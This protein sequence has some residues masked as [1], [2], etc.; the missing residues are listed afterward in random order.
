[1][2]ENVYAVLIPEISIQSIGM[3]GSISESDHMFLSIINLQKHWKMREYK[4]LQSFTHIE[5]H[6]VS[7]ILEIMVTLGAA[8]TMLIVQ[9]LLIGRM[10]YAPQ[11]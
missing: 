7:V 4:F 8:T 9:S 6:L 10:K 5:I 3:P 1:M 2:S 11:R